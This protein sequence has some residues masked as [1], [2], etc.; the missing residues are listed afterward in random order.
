VSRARTIGIAILAVLAVV[1]VLQ[2]TAEIETRFLFFSIRAPRAVLLTGTLFIGF[3][4]GVL[5]TWTR[6]RGR[7]KP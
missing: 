1:V 7:K 2:N 6:E 4:L 5:A 3:A